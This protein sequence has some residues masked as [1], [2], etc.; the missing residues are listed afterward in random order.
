MNN[1]TKNTLA[2]FYLIPSIGILLMLL[3]LFFVGN[4][5]SISTFE[6]IEFMYTENSD[7]NLFVALTIIM[8]TLATMVALFL[9]GH[10]NNKKRITAC[11]YVVLAFVILTLALQA[12]FIS[13]II[14]PALI[15]TYIN[16]K[17]A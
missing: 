4:G 17:N 10:I 13:L 11:F 5:E 1:K 16:I 7:S 14:L 2:L 3:I 8:L 15:Y 9:N 6:I 12:N